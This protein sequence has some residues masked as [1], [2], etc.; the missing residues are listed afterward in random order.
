MRLKS[1]NMGCGA[2]AHHGEKKWSCMFHR[3]GFILGLLAVDGFT[4]SSYNRNTSEIRVG[5]HIP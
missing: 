3:E 5:I 1:N 4:T 2:A